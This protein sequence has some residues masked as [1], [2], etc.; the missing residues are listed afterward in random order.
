MG[1]AL[2]AGATHFLVF[3]KNS[4]GEYG[5]PGSTIITDAVLPKAKPL[6]MSFD[7]EDGDRGHISG[8][9][10][11]EGPEG[12]NLIDEFAIHWGK[13]SS[14][15]LASNSHV[16]S[17][18]VT[19][20]SKK[21]EKDGE[22]KESFTVK[23]YFSKNT[24]VPDG[25]THLLAYSKNTHGEHPQGVSLKI[26][27]RVKP[28]INRTDAS[29]PA[30]VTI[31]RVADG[32]LPMVSDIASQEVRLGV[33]RA[34]D[35]AVVTSYSMYWGRGD[36]KEGGQSGAKNGHIKDVPLT[37]RGVTH[38]AGPLEHTVPVGA[39]VPGGTTHVLAFTKN[40]V[41][42]SNHC[43]SASFAEEEKSEEKPA[44]KAEL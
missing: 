33:I 32:S 24:K 21:D 27:D 18:S 43:V 17:V 37:H 29:C 39:H 15:K 11:I 14:K 26:V 7:D 20:S 36:C 41:G 3:S 40:A 34:S 2:P 4:H 6:K 13:S 1:T 8:N 9:L 44:D 12:D 16:R 10:H 19:S 30:G 38:G 31:V 42:E 5:T 25:A 35:E 28:C 22:K 23:H